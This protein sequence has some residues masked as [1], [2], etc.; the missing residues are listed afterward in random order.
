MKIALASDH[1]G[2]ELKDFI[3]Q[4]LEKQ[5]HEVKDYGTYT[6]E[7]C[8]YTDFAELACDAVV[9]GQSERGILFCGTGIGM[10]I[11]A[12][13]IKG[14]YAALVDNTFSA[15]MTR[16][17][18]DSNVLVMPGRLIGKDI[19][20]EIAGIWIATQYEGGR[21]DR[22]LNKIKAVENKNMK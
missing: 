10:S 16:R 11:V 5:G 17:H 14:I 15:A 12:N 8:D 19:A 1:A 20:K 2:L 21:H 3:K 13:K 9:K 22:R 18:N 7:S 6:E 4:H